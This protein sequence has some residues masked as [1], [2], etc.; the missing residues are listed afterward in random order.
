MP[1]FSETRWWSWGSGCRLQT[2]SGLT[3]PLE[4]SAVG[5]L[6][7]CSCRLIALGAGFLGC[8]RPWK[9]GHPAAALSLTLGGLLGFQVRSPRPVGKP[10]ALLWP[11]GASALAVGFCRQLPRSER[12]QRVPNWL[13]LATGSAGSPKSA[14]A[15]PPMPPSGE[16][17][18]G[19]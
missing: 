19:G 14:G 4:V 17:R 1:A 16:T 15:V 9:M 3:L 2:L 5:L 7:N 18:G 12:G 8:F 13:S 10:G 11:L 6:S